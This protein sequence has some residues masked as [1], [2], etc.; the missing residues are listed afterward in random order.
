MPPVAPRDVSS[1]YKAPQN[2]TAAISGHTAELLSGQQTPCS[3]KKAMKY[4][5]AP[6]GKSHVVNGKEGC[7]ILMV[8]LHPYIN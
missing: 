7:D 5:G 4:G 8:K 6:A 3:R 1:W 2:L